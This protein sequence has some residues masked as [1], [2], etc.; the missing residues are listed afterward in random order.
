MKKLLVCV[1]V[2]GI[3]AGVIYLLC[4]KNK[5]ENVSSKSTDEKFDSEVVTKEENSDK[6]KDAIQQMNEAKEKSA[7][8][9]YERHSEA[10]GIMTDAFNNILKEVDPV[11]LED[12]TVESII[13]TQDVEV[14]K[15]LDSL[16]D[17]LD[18]LL[19]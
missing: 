6:E 18:E 12:E 11:E 5:N 8:T 4:K 15:E 1:A 19:K 3:A 16:A 10:T 9:V 14:I 7:Q 13:D 17:E 2:T